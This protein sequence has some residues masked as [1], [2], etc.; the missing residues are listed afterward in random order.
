[1]RTIPSIDSMVEEALPRLHGKDC[2][3]CGRPGPIDLHDAY[4]CHSFLVVTMHGRAPLVG[5]RRCGL[6]H[7]VKKVFSTGLF[8]W[9][10]MRGLL[11]TPLQLSRTLK[12]MLLAP[13][14]REPS[15]LL[16]EHVRTLM[17][18][19]RREVHLPRCPACKEAYDPDDYREDAERILCSRCNGELPR[20]THTARE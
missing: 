1:M 9:W 5:C 10:A 8:G 17:T 13:N 18:A 14:P 6:T 7:Q 16:R 11:L 2:P 20:E 19:L 15:Q 4:W 12:A 3:S